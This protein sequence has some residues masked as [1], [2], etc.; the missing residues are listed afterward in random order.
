MADI[1]TVSYTPD[2]IRVFGDMDDFMGLPITVVSTEPALSC[3]TPMGQIT[4][5]SKYK[6]YDKDAVDGSQNF[7]GFLQNAVNPTAEGKDVQAAIW[8]TGY[9]DN[10]KVTALGW[11]ATALAATPGARVI[12]GRNILILPGA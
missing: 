10:A 2:E 9:F 7:A 11:N 8:I 12:A 4:A 3:G 6:K 1:T 5:S